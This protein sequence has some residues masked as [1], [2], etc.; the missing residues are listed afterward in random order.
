MQATMA[1]AEM[2]D[3]ECWR[4]RMKVGGDTDF[5][6]AAW[7][8]G[9]AGVWYGA[10][11]ADDWHA[12]ISI[13]PAHPSSVLRDLP[14]QV[15][16]GWGDRLDLS[17]VRRFEAI[18]SRDW[19]VV[20]LKDRREIALAHLEPGLWSEDDHPLNQDYGGGR[21][22]VFKYRRM[23]D[24]KSFKVAHLPDAYRLIGAQ[25]RS[26]NVHRFHAMRSHVRLLAEQRDEA[27][28]RRALGALSL[29]DLIESLG[30]SAWESICTA[31]LI[32]EHG[33]VPTGLSI[34]LTLEAVDIVGRRV[35]DGAHVL[36]Q[37]KK[38]GHS[39]AIEESFLSAVEAQ[40]AGC[41]AFY[42]AFGGCHGDVPD[43]IRVVGR[44]EM[45]A[46]TDTERGRRYRDFLL[47]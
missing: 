20:Y 14:V 13:N 16:L 36:A 15:A 22:E 24:R 11:S 35:N 44:D 25:G 42:F 19:C 29:S 6:T 26:G 5:S 47:G 17:A 27:G 12:A 10:W 9:E 37:C 32:L 43:H 2:K 31:Y 45:L 18:G 38:D 4:V 39:V 23:S 30:A 7:D 33:F 41:Q 28:V 21:K 8:R 3:Y 34:G 40:G 1:E 46:W